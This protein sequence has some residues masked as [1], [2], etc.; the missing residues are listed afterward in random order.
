[1]AKHALPLPDGQKLLDD[2]LTEA[3]RTGKRVLIFQSVPLSAPSALLNLFLAA[4]KEVLEKDY[5]CL[6]LSPRY[7]GTPAAIQP[8][9]GELR[10][11]PWLA[12]LDQSGKSLASTI[13]PA[14]PDPP[15]GARVAELLQSTAR[16]LTNDDIQ[17]LVKALWIP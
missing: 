14:D 1:M 8:A 11:I 6:M 15:G 16:A 10:P 4:R 12:V 2:A 17:A 7:F 9:G 5:V 13:K 3:K